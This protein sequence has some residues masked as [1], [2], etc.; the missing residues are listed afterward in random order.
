MG[1][2]MEL[3]NLIGF[4]IQH[5]E[6]YVSELNIV[7]KKLK[8]LNHRKFIEVADKIDGLLYI[9]GWTNKK[10]FITDDG[11]CWY[12]R[13][14]SN[15]GHARAVVLFP[16]KLDGINFDRSVNVYTDL[17]VPEED[18][19]GLMG[20]ITNYLSLKNSDDNLVF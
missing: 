16:G 18:L 7:M 13:M 15:L 1:I 14:E 10:E 17:D 11:Y 4:P 12:G 20:D 3:T 8:G 9:I 19:R 6:E 5:G 2:V